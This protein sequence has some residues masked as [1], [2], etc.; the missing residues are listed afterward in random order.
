MLVQLIAATIKFNEF[1]IMD[2]NNL[3]LVEFKGKH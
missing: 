2:Y 1:L 3:N